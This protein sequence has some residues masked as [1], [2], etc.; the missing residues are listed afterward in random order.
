[1]TRTGRSIKRSVS[2]AT[3][4]GTLL[5]LAG[6]AS[7]TPIGE[8]LDNSTRYDSKT[9]RIEGE[10][11]T[12]AGALGVGAYQV[13]DKTGTLTV[14]SEHGTAPRTGS[15]VEVKGKFEALFTLLGRSLAVLREESRSTP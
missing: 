11:E 2:L 5:V 9:V 13:K 10:V 15:K 8:L 4:A 3:L 7:A 6:C 14:V 12:S 1:M